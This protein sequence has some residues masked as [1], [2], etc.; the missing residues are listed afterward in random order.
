MDDVRS[1]SSTAVVAPAPRQ[2]L[3]R[4]LHGAL[5]PWWRLHVQRFLDE[6][7]HELVHRADRAPHSADQ[8]HYWQTRSEL[9]HHRAALETGMGETLGRAFR[10]WLEHRPTRAAVAVEEAGLARTLAVMASQLGATCAQALQP[11]QQ[12]LSVLSMGHPVDD[13]HNPVAPHVFGH[14]LLEAMAPLTLDQRARERVADRYQAFLLQHLPALY[15]LLNHQLIK[16]GVLPHVGGNEPPR[17][18]HGAPA[19]L[20]AVDPD[21]P[22]RQQQR[23]VRL[24]QR[25][26]G[27]GR[28]ASTTL[29]EQAL[30]LSS[31]QRLAGSRLPSHDEPGEWPGSAEELARR[32]QRDHQ[33]LQAS[34]HGRLVAEWFAALESTSLSAELVGLLRHLQPVLLRLVVSDQLLLQQPGHPARQ[35]LNSLV[36]AGEHWVGEGVDLPE[37]ELRQTLHG[38]VQRLLQEFEPDNAALA[39][40]LRGL[41]EVLHRHGVQVQR[42]RRRA[43]SAAAGEDQLRDGRQRV[44]RFL[45]RRCG[46]TPLTAAARELLFGPWAHYLTWV[47]L[48]FGQ[49]SEAWEESV[50]AVDALLHYLSSPGRS[51][52]AHERLLL[53]GLRSGLELVGYTAEEVEARFH[54]MMEQRTGGAPTAAVADYPPEVEPA[55]EAPPQGSWYWLADE[56]GEDTES[57]R[58]GRWLQLVWRSEHTGQLLLVTASGEWGRLVA[59]RDLAAWQEQGL[60]RCRPPLDTTPFVERALGWIDDSSRPEQVEP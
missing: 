44:D 46:L 15:A 47:L 57:Q 10:A 8:D 36:A 41:H 58:P 40:E 14:A 55:L 11:L 38:T 53:A 3:L 1:P 25:W 50:D 19:E 26:P 30:A 17:R 43:C 7:D 21:S 4:R 22:H 60:V 34:D 33:P 28:P 39:G 12:R 35:L 2:H 42:Q 56:A 59:A 32:L 31:L 45:H 9:S 29:R 18:L 51:S 13:E 16:H 24:L 23:V 48:R 54:A 5:A 20:V 27:L 52:A 6:L 49:G 37:Q